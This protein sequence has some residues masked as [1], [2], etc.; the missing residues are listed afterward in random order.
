MKCVECFKAG[1]FPTD[2]FY[3]HL[4]KSLCGSCLPKSIG[5]GNAIIAIGSELQNMLQESAK[6][7]RQVSARMTLF[8][9]A[10]EPKTPEGKA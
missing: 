4:G 1:R 10:I 2:A 7:S 9:D 5:D 3:V 8:L 6:A